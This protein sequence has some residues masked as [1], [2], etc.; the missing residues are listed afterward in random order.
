MLS[1]LGLSVLYFLQIQP[2]EVLTLVRFEDVERRYILRFALH[3][4]FRLYKAE[5]IAIGLASLECMIYP[6]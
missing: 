5:S 1:Y 6:N 2:H 4:R 3:E